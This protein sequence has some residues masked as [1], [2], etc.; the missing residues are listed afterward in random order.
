VKHGQ[1]LSRDRIGSDLGVEVSA[2]AVDGLA[3]FERLLRERALP[4]GLVAEGDRDRLLERH[5][6]DCLRA[7]VAVTEADRLA[8]DMGSGAGLPGVVV[9]IARPWLRVLLVEPRRT[10]AAFLE[11]AVERLALDNA[12][13]HVGRIEDV[14]EPADL[15]FARAFAPPATAW[16]LALP[17]L[18]PGGRLVYFGELPDELGTLAGAREV[19]VLRSPVLESA[20]PLTIM[21]R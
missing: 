1:P 5:V 14:T 4:M 12:G 19:S 13:V 10:R 2:E 20:G 7:L 9:A 17:R 11:L 3:A 6:L 21:A 8:Y 15:C 18:R 16:E